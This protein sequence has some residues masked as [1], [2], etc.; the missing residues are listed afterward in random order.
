MDIRFVRT[1]V[2]PFYTYGLLF[3]VVWFWNDAG[4]FL[5]VKN[6]A[7]MDFS[8]YTYWI[9]YRINWKSMFRN[10]LLWQHGFCNYNA[11][12]NEP[13]WTISVCFFLYYAF[14]LLRKYLKKIYISF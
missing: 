13:A 7:H 14:Y 6:L 4:G 11:N 10:L 2:L 3:D 8:H 5:R 12:I 9:Y 1:G